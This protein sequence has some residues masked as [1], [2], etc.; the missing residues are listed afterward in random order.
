M[1]NYAEI[2]TVIRPCKTCKTDTEQERQGVGKD[3]R[4]L[5]LEC[6]MDANTVMSGNNRKQGR[7]F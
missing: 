6:L 3:R 4:Y 7:L 5:C 1:N 2:K